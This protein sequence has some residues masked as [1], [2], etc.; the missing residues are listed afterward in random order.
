MTTLLEGLSGRPRNEQAMLGA[1]KIMSVDGIYAGE[2]I[3]QVFG[4]KVISGFK[5]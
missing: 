1:L 4:C 5:H 2:F 3:R